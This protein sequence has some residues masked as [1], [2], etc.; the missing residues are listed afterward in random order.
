M[1]LFN[2]ATNEVTL[3]LV[4][5]GPGLA[6]K[7]TNLCWIHEHAPFRSKGKLVSLATQADLTLFFD[8]VPLE[9]ATVAGMR[10]RI[11]VYTVPGRVF[12]ETTRR[13]VLEGCDAVVFVADS[14]ASMLDANVEGLRGLRQNLLVNHLDPALPQVIQYNKRDL[15]TALPLALLEA[16]LNS[17]GLPHY[18]AVALEGVGVQETLGGITSL[19]FERLARPVRGT[20]ATPTPPPARES[21]TDAGARPAGIAPL[22]AAV[23]SRAAP[24]RRTRRRR[25]TAGRPRLGAG[26]VALPPERPSTGPRNVRRAGR[27]RA[28]LRA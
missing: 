4:Y 26:P 19:V 25:A 3:K 17:R 14:Q 22:A 5:Y 21:A 7:T 2:R 16:Q 13:M 27:P 1:P 15:A 20:P 9:P 23:V 6:G 28:R 11:Q 24:R 12:Y 8:F 10:P 18:E